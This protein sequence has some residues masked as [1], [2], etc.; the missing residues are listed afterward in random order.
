MK[1]SG[2]QFLSIFHAKLGI[3]KETVTK[4]TTSNP[5]LE[6]T[7][8]LCRGCNP[9]KKS[10]TILFLFLT[11]YFICFFIEYLF[12]IRTNQI[13]E[14]IQNAKKNSLFISNLN[15]KTWYQFCIAPI[16][17]SWMTYLFV[18]KE[19]LTDYSETG[20]VTNAMIKSERDNIFISWSNPQYKHDI[21]QGYVVHLKGP[22]NFCRT[23]NI[24]MVNWEKLLEF[25]CLIIQTRIDI[26]EDK[27]CLNHSTTRWSSLKTL[28]IKGLEPYS[29]FQIEIIP[30]NR[31]KSSEK[32]IL[33]IKTKE[34]GMIIDIK[35]WHKFTGVNLL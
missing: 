8:F 22:N 19:L 21:P 3:M 28:E 23:V 20:P 30:F 10:L 4:F 29:E 5:N 32:T 6:S 2:L 14:L 16:D 26:P 17:G 7:I 24:K 31:H 27:K 35:F 13:M 12:I 34:R 11:S 15:E 33:S 25:I 1:K 18:C 9:L